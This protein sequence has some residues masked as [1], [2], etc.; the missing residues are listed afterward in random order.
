MDKNKIWRQQSL[1]RRLK[2]RFLL[3]RKNTTF[4][5]GLFFIL[6]CIIGTIGIYFTERG[7]NDGI[8]GF[9]DTI[10]YTIVTISTV[11]YGDI[12][13]VT[14]NGK[15][16]GFFLILFGVAITGSIT[17][18]I[19]SFLVSRELKESKG[20]STFNKISGHYLICGYKKNLRDIIINILRL[21]PHLDPDKVVLIN[22]AD[23][24]TIQNLRSDKD[25]MAIKYVN[26]E[27]IDE[28]T[29]I[30]AN[31][32]EASTALI[33]EDELNDSTAQERDAQTVL[34][35]MTMKNINKN[36]YV[37][38]EILDK[39]FE[40]HLRIYGC[41]EILLTQEH[42]R[43]MLANAST[44]SGLSHIINDLTSVNSGS[45][46]TTEVIPSTYIGKTYA[47]LADSF[48][49]KNQ[50]LVLGLLEN[51]GN[52]NARKKEALLEAQK[53]PNVTALVENLR[54]VK[55]LE[56]NKPVLNPPNDYLIKK[57]TLAILI[58][59]LNANE[60]EVA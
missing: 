24:D 13:P 30:R 43:I 46:V 32:S 39:R 48:K 3:I 2:T 40:K 12:S 33:L 10:W 5:I 42:S 23:P 8:N 9:F 21:N 41:D 14:V 51:T 7:K 31:V 18:N 1:F 4:Q 6:V 29:L 58:P 49:N 19:A 54:S 25:L 37:I 56:S 59:P 28:N 57:N 38:A 60:I 22:K 35:L 20:M 11:G 50:T 15:L 36:L 52:I 27:H 17:A 53:T 16:L 26:G 47:E 55:G 44:A 34:A 45:R